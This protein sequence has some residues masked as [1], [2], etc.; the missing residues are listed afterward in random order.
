MGRFADVMIDRLSASELDQFEH[1]MHAPDPELYVWIVGEVAPPPAYDC[2][3]LHSLR[4][5]HQRGGHI[6]ERA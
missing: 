5:F 6:G 1:L 4:A 3:V 2:P